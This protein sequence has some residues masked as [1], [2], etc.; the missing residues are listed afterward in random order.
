VPSTAG[1][2]RMHFLSG[3]P[4]NR[5]HKDLNQV[6]V[7]AAVLNLT[8]SLQTTGTTTELFLVVLSCIKYLCGF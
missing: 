2:E 4:T 8:R 3:C 7:E 6:T 1:C 5:S